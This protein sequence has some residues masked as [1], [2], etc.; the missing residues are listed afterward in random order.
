MSTFGEN[1][2]KYRKLNGMTQAV[3]AERLGYK[4]KASIGKIENGDSDLPLSMAQKIA[5]VLGVDIIAL[6][7]G[8]S[9][10]ALTEKERHLIETYRSNDNF[11]QSVDGIIAM[12]SDKKTGMEDCSKMA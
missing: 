8:V 12:L 10:S 4:N 2:R 1:V 3:L 9:S 6:I 5:D 7:H 11:R